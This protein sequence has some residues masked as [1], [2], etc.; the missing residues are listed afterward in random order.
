MEQEKHFFLINLQITKL[1]RKSELLSY[2]F[3]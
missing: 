3:W 1:E 2:L